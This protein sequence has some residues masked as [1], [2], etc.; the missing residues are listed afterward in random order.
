MTQKSFG[1]TLQRTTTQNHYNMSAMH[2]HQDYELYFL[3]SG[4]RKYFLG[5]TIYDIAP[6]N[7]VFIPMGLLHR[8]VALGTKGFDRYVINFSQEHYD[9]LSAIAGRDFLA[10]Y[11]RGVCFQL[12]PDKVRH[13][14]RRLEQMEHELSAPGKWT[15]AASITILYDILLESLRYGECKAP[16]Q[17]ETAD[18]IQQAAKYI[19][20]HYSQWMTLEDIASLVHMEK[21]YFSRRFKALT[22]FGFLDYLTQTRLRASEDLLIRTDLSIREIS[23]SCGFSGSNYFGDVFRRYHNISPTEYRRNARNTER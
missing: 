10:A 17:E 7:V 6:G 8:T 21:T 9:A 5:H 11:P 18:K 1:F 22:G 14:H 23:D 2:S 13:I 16:C 4:Q 19:S 20:E 15:Q 3:I 12:P